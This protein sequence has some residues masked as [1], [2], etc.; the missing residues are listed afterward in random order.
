MKDR[1]QETGMYGGWKRVGK[2]MYVA[3]IPVIPQSK[4]FVD[5]ARQSRARWDIVAYLKSK[6]S[7]SPT[8]GTPMEAKK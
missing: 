8:S 6:L 5:F 1:L 3:Q 7:K 4:D 2:D